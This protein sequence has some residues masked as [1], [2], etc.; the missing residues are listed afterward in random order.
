M[1]RTELHVVIDPK[2]NVQTTVKGVPGAA[3]KTVLEPFRAL[4]RVT[5]EERTSEYY[6]TESDH[7]VLL[8]STDR[9]N[10]H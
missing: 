5:R 10:P 1:K 7:A 4:G 2:G 3:C 8:E 6:G 9:N